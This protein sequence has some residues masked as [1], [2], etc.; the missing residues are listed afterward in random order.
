MRFDAWF[1]MLQHADKW[2]GWSD[3]EAFLKLAG[4]LRKRA[5][6]EWNTP[7][8]VTRS[9]KRY[10]SAQKFEIELLVQFESA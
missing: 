5:I 6:L 1:L 10:I 7:E 3:E 8:Y 2:N 4:H 9:G